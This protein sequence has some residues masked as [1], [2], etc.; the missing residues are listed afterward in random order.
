MDAF[1]DESPEFA[2]QGYKFET[3]F[4]ANAIQTDESSSEEDSVEEQDH[5]DAPL[6]FTLTGKQSKC[7]IC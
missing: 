7:L 5:E 6:L 1:S 3:V 2:V 4:N